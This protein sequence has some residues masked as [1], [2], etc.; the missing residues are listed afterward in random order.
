MYKTNEMHDMLSSYI[1]IYSLTLIL[2][3]SQGTNLSCRLMDCLVRQFESKSVK[4]RL[5]EYLMNSEKYVPFQNGSE[6]LIF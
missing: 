6:Q 2:S 3:T 5:I 4:C 1:K